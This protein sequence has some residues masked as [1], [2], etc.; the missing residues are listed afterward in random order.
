MLHHF[1]RS[2]LFLLVLT[3]AFAT[4]AQML[5]LENNVIVTR[6]IAQRNQDAAQRKFH[7]LKMRHCI[8]D[9]HIENA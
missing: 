4:F 6:N 5:R 1:L 8:S 2:L 3:P 7:V 9:Q